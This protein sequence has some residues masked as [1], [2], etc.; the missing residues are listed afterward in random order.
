MDTDLMSALA[1]LS[2]LSGGRAGQDMLDPY[3]LLG[4]QPNYY[5]PYQIYDQD[6]V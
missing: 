5:D 3:G 4:P 1:I 6:V 2:E